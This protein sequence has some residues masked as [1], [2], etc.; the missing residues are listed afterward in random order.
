[1]GYSTGPHARKSADGKDNGR[2]VPMQGQGEN[3]QKKGKILDGYGMMYIRL[4][5]TGDRYK[6]GWGEFCP[7]LFPGGGPR[8]RPGAAQGRL[9]VLDPFQVQ[10]V[11][12]AIPW[13]FP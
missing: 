1:M 6:T 4:D 11:D 5:Q 7:P 10:W 2:E 3:E 13:G 9:P 8:K 12:E